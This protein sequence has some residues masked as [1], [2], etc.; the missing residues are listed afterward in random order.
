MWEL[1]KQLS[2]NL[3]LKG[4]YQANPLQSNP[5]KFTPIPS[6]TT[7]ASSNILLI[8]IQSNSAEKHWYLGA[9]ISQYLYISPSTSSNFVQGVE[10][11]DQ[12]RVKLNNL[13]LISFKDYGIYPYVLAIEIPYWLK[14]IYV[15][16]W[17]YNQIVTDLTQQFNIQEIEQKLDRIEYK[18]DNQYMT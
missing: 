18:I 17:E 7:S 13:T 11:S 12:K 16:I 9:R 6:I 2:W 3:I 10:T 14:D 5:K 8:G 4:N 1:S 15:E